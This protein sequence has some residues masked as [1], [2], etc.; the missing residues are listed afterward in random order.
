MEVDTSPLGH[1]DRALRA[2]LE[3]WGLS[4]SLRLQSF[5]F[6]ERLEIDDVAC[7]R[8]LFGSPAVARWLA[9]AMGGAE[10]AMPP[11]K[12]VPLST[13][14]TSLAFFDPLEAAFVSPGGGV[15]QCAHVLLEG[16][17]IHDVLRKRL[18]RLEIGIGLDGEPA[19]SVDED[20]DFDDAP[21]PDLPKDLDSTELIFHL[22][23]LLAIG[24]S[25][26]QHDDRLDAY[27]ASTKALYRALVA[28]YRT[29]AT[30]DIAI[31]TKAFR[32]YDPQLFPSDSRLQRCYVLLERRT[33]LAT[34]LQC[35]R[36]GW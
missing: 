15:K 22:F 23:S 19:D 34:I 36:L 24:G 21:P 30:G 3:R 6:E 7:V 16:A 26:C 28:V 13:T 33:R 8:T 4:T 35:N 11:R 18:V 17:A 1:D 5:R 25:M 2:N 12:V 27:L 10:V 32:I 31:S 9:Q 14:A 29:K 20:D